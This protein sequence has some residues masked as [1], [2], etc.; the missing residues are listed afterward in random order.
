M[1]LVWSLFPTF[2]VLIKQDVFW[3]CP[4]CS[5]LLFSSFAGLLTQISIKDNR[6]VEPKMF[7]S[8][9]NIGFTYSVIC[10][11]QWPSNSSEEITTISNQPGVLWMLIVLWTSVAIREHS[12]KISHGVVMKIKLMVGVKVHTTSILPFQCYFSGH[13]LFCWTARLDWLELFV[14]ELW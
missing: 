11:F 10:W 13:M 9:R 6:S 8:I 12:V 4:R 7:H 14:H 2:H 5:S 1:L 3:Y